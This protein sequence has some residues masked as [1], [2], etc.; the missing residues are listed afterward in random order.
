MNWDM[1]DFFK[2]FWF[3]WLTSKRLSFKGPSFKGLSFKGVRLRLEFRFTGLENAL[4]SLQIS[5]AKDRAWIFVPCK[6]LIEDL[7]EKSNNNK[8][9]SGHFGM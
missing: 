8:Y 7:S 5:I 1:K 2:D 3:K 4:L 9:I 6:S